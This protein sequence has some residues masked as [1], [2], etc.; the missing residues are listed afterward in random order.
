MSCR[1]IPISCNV[2]T[3]TVIAIK[4]LCRNERLINALYLIA[5][6]SVNYSFTP[7]WYY[8]L[9]QQSESQTPFWQKTQ[10]Q[11][12]M[13]PIAICV[14]ALILYSISKPQQS[15]DTA[16]NQFLPISILEEGNLS[17][18]EYLRKSEKVYSNGLPEYWMRKRKGNIV[19]LFPIIPGILNVPTFAVAKTFGMNLVK[20]RVLLSHITGA[21]L[22]SLSALFIFKFMRKLGIRWDT[23]ILFMCVYAFATC[24]WGIASTGIWQHGPSLFMLL[25]GILLLLHERKAMQITSGF[26][27]ACAVINRPTN[28]ILCI[29]IGIYVL[30]YKR[31]IVWQFV[32]AGILPLILS[33][34]YS[35]VYWGGPFDSLIESIAAGARTG[36]G[37]IWPYTEK[38]LGHLYSPS[39][40]IISMSPIFIFS[41]IFGARC[42]FD[43][44]CHPLIRLMSASVPVYIVIYARAAGYGGWTF[45]YRYLVE[46]IP[47]LIVLLAMYWEKTLVKA[48]VERAIFWV[49]LAFSVYVQFLGAFYLTVALIARQNQ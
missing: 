42:I 21:I 47:I 35:V 38:I 37:G 7:L 2:T 24:A 43:K 15:G 12:W 5:C 33:C 4:N 9:M 6:L 39:R 10:I 46:I 18:N 30:F 20:N 16:P 27:L 13:I 40:G 44:T 28:I 8:P 11:E 36:P 17:L 3:I 48:P 26:V 22:T 23:S 32:A 49:F 19:S 45:G 41:F 14:A 29:P 31:E 34:I 1:N 25:A